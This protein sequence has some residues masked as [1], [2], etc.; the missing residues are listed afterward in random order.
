M[1]HAETK[2]L[3]PT[4]D[5]AE[6]N[7]EAVARE[8]ANDPAVDNWE[9]VPTNDQAVP[10]SDQAVRTREHANDPEYL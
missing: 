9:A 5:Q 3:V 8:H 6:D 7:W 1:E 4:N 10:T 2:N